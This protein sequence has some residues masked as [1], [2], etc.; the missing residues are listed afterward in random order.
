M[1]EGYV[2]RPG[3]GKTYTLTKRVL[4]IANKRPVFSNYPID[5]PNVTVF[6]PK[7]LMRLPSGVIVLDEAHLYFPARGALKLP[8]SWLTMLSQ[9]R[10]MGWDLIWST[11]HE[12]RIDAVVRDVTNLMWWCKTYGLGEKPWLF[13]A[14]AYEPEYFRKPKM[15]MLRSYHRFDQKVADAYDTYGFVQEA[16]HLRTVDAYRKEGE[17]VSDVRGSSGGGDRRGDGSRDGGGAIERAATDGGIDG[18]SGGADR[19]ARVLAGTEVRSGGSDSEGD[20][21]RGSEGSSTSSSQRDGESGGRVQR[22]GGR[23]AEPF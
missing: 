8:M 7:D 20:S 1:I 12:R 3:S 13:T 5:H 17:G 4:K 21:D 19:W 2:G 18:A 9:T 15:A 23:S 6:E 14:R 11:Q 22:V 16:D 10:K